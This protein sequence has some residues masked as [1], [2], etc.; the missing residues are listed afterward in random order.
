[1]CGARGQVQDQSRSCPPDIAE[2]VGA[3]ERE[4]VPVGREGKKG[5]RR[6]DREKKTRGEGQGSSDPLRG[7]TGRQTATASQ[8]NTS[9]VNGQALLQVTSAP[10][11][12]RKCF[13]TFF[14]F[15]LESTYIIQSFVPVLMLDK[16]KRVL[17]HAIFDAPQPVLVWTSPNMTN[18]SR[19]FRPCN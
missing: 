19:Q 18:H 10:P 16:R 17:L 3:I 7:W 6:M 13:A 14:V 12:V 8:V 5:Q 2:Q 11:D 1:M 4:A 9:Q 15:S